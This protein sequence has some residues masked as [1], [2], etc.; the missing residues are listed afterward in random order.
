MLN[1]DYGSANTG[2]LVDLITGA[3]ELTQVPHAQYTDGL[4]WNIP[5][6][7]FYDSNTSHLV[8][9]LVNESGYP[10]GDGFGGQKTVSYA[11]RRKPVPAWLSN[12]PLFTWHEFPNSNFHVAASN[13]SDAS[14]AR[15]V[16]SKWAG[17]ENASASLGGNGRGCL[18]GL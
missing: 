7:T 18:L 14:G 6:F 10:I 13:V 9:G 17:A 8:Y 15:A 12:L 4:G 11:L 5:T 3:V 1:G 2:V 16:R